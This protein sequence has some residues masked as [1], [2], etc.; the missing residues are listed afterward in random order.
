MAS[1]T[2]TP[3][4]SP[5]GKPAEHSRVHDADADRGGPEKADK[6]ASVSKGPFRSGNRIVASKRA[7][8]AE[9]YRAV[10]AETSSRRIRDLMTAAS[11]LST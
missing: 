4:G 9:V 8:I 5:K 7:E 10:I 1:Q 6:M 3:V 11:C 2:S